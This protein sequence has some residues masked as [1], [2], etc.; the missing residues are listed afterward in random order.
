MYKNI[1]LIIIITII[2]GCS[3]PEPQISPPSW[4][5]NVPTNNE[6]FY[7]AGTA[8]TIE[9]AKKNA[10]VSMRN[11]LNMQLNAAFKN[12]KYN[13]KNLDKNLLEDIFAY[14]EI[15][16]KKISIKKIT[17]VKSKAFNGKQIVLISILRSKLFLKL[18]HISNIELSRVKQEY[19]ARRKSIAIKRFIVLD[20]LMLNYAKIAS[21]AGYKK[22]LVPPYEE[23]DEFSFL[24]KMKDEYDSLKEHIN[25][26]ILSDANSKLFALTIK[27]ILKEKGLNT[28]NDMNSKNALKL[29]IT[30][31]TGDS[32]EYSFN[33]SE[34]LIK[35]TTFDIKKNKISFKQHTFVGKSKKDAEDAKQHAANNLKYKIKKL[36][37]FNFIG[38]KK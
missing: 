31:A 2:A 1:L 29:L 10:I 12:K 14:N 16:S 33:R 13:L 19:Q 32:R 15:V 34:S 18:K 23:Y 24:N 17:L 22:F 21:L 4:Y 27:S 9:N 20:S 26:Y 11:S 5:T 36:G 37:I 6:L 30:S 35:F 8:N 38:F 25:I 3:K 7:A 28:R